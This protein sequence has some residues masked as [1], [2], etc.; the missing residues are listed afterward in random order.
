M[1]DIFTYTGGFI[2]F[3]VLMWFALNVWT[4]R[5]PPS[6]PASWLMWSIMD[7]L[8]LFTTLANHQPGWLP[9]GWTLG[10]SSVTAVLLV[11]GKW[12]WSYKETICA[13]G[14]ATATYAW[15]H[16]GAIT[17]L[18]SGIIAMNVAGI[19][20]FIDMWRNPIRGTWPVWGFSTIACLFTLLGSDWSFGGIILAAS[21]MFFNGMLTLVVLFRKRDQC[22]KSVVPL[23]Y[24]LSR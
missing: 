24:T 22:Q 11:R 16:Y 2:A 10:A 9:G 13:I 21:S 4:R 1:K 19:P 3:S 8:L 6:T 15:L 23:P 20:N 12:S 18:L 14:A 17:G 7:S 5:V